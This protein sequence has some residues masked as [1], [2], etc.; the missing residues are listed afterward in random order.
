MALAMT[1][2]GA[3]NPAKA[4]PLFDIDVPANPVNSAYDVS[5]D[6]RF[7]VRVARQDPRREPLH[8]YLGWSPGSA[9]LD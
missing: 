2:T 7:L 5:D 4:T 6:G 9:P 8:V 1:A 3:F